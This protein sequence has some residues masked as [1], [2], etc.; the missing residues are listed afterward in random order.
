MTAYNNIC[1]TNMYCFI[2]TY[3][4]IF[5]DQSAQNATT[6]SERNM[7]LVATLPNKQSA[8]LNKVKES[9]IRSVCGQQLFYSLRAL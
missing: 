7:L 6:S 2:H 9:Y 8:Q 1:K 4:K 5:K 3:I